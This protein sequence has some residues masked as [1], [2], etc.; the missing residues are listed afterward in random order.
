M[1]LFVAVNALVLVTI[2]IVLQILGIRP[3]LTAYGIDYK[4]LMAFC[5]V[6]GMGGSFISLG[7]SRIMAKW[8]MEVQVIDP[9]KE[10]GEL[11]KLVRTVHRLARSANLLMER[12]FVKNST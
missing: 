2:S 3:Y 10:G 12:R 9:Q 4:A 6:W 8:M 1:L 7:F 5:L 11:G